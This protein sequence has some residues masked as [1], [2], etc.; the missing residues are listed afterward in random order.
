[1]SARRRPEAACGAISPALL[2]AYR[3]TAYVAAGAVV[4]IGRRSDAMD[5][6]LVRAGS[7]QGVFVTA[8]NPLSRR[9][10]EGWNR[11]MQLCLAARLRRCVC[12]PAEG[13]LRRWHEAHLLV[14]GNPRPVLRLARVFRQCGVVVVARG[15]PARLVLLER[16]R[17]APLVPPGRWSPGYARR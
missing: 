13:S 16:W 2:R 12:V 17:P 8:W 4:R 15:Q 10:P 9:M 6:L 11:R 3:A 1:M 5:A 7:R 14:L